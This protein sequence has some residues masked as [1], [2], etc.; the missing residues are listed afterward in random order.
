MHG[1]PRRGV[2]P[3]RRGWAGHGAVPSG[4]RGRHGVVSLVAPS[5]EADDRA[6]AV[7]R[8]VFGYAEFRAGQGEAVSA[9]LGGRD[10]VVVLPTGA[11]KSLCYQ[12]PAIAASQEGRGTTVVVSPLIA[13]M[14]DQVGALRGR[15][16]AAAAIHSHQDEADRRSVLGALTRGELDLLYVSPERAALPSFRR[17]LERVPIAHLA[18]DEAHCISEWGHDFR[19]EYMRLGELR[20]V[21]S[22]PA[23]AL[24]ATATPEV[25]REIARRL[26]L[27]EPALV[28]GSFRRPNLRFSV[29]HLRSDADRVAAILEE[30]ETAGLRGRGG[31]SSAGRAI[32]YCS[33]RAKTEAFAKALRSAGVAVGYYHAGRTK[34]ARERAQRAFESGRTRVLVATN[35]F[36]MGIDHPDVRLLVHAQAPGSLEAYYQ[37]A[38]RAGRDGLPARCILFFGPGD[39]VT[40][41]RLRGG[42]SAGA[43]LEDRAEAALAAVEAYATG[44]QCRQKV[45]CAHFTES[46]EEPPC[47]NCDV[48]E[49]PDAVASAQV[50]ETPPARE[51]TPLDDEAREQIVAAAGNLRR[52]V[53]KTNFARALRGSRAKA[54]RRLGLLDLPEHGSLRRCDEASIVAAIDDLLEAGSLARRG[55]KYPTVWLPGRPVRET[56]AP[57]SGPSKPA[58]RSRRPRT[59]DLSRALENYR[60][61][62]AR[63]LDWKPY[64]VYQRK[65][66]AAIDVRR[67]RTLD[68]LG[69]IPGLGPAKLERFGDDLLDLVRRHGGAD[70]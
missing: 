38:G 23:I 28:R 46:D 54:L 9:L 15:G 60:R 68:E 36:G 22:S 69:S 6:R 25:T 63:N 24:T 51:I 39:L 47:G 31:K 35:A 43:A 3:S 32:L 53:G 34:L 4:G 50:S 17:L 42:Q 56:S 11:G 65:V 19:P 26:Q 57:S 37:E 59:T 70:E 18:I 49:D 66:I 12:V 58:R 64:M 30:L 10:A 8:E 48:C 61:R 5:L 7:L 16:V 67:P 21:V 14:D 62:A 44:L 13:L 45:L 52:P 20:E 1:L 2:F 55:K 40:Q 27:R 33:T 41:R 29:S